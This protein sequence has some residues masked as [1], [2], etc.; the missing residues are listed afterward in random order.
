MR[1]PPARPSRGPQIRIQ[2]C[3]R[4]V[5]S[6][7]V[8][9]TMPKLRMDLNLLARLGRFNGAAPGNSAGFRAG[10]ARTADCRAGMAKA[11]PSSAARLH[12]GAGRLKLSLVSC[13]IAPFP[14]T[15]KREKISFHQIVRIPANGS[16]IR[17]STSTSRATAP[18]GA[19]VRFT[20]DRDQIADIAEGPSRASL[21]SKCRSGRRR[22]R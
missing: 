3:L 11:P 6:G 16:S 14:A 10:K 15:S 18:A 13:P 5:P 12:Q 22:H 8:R 17:R 4:K 21:H 1:P 20:R 9:Q 7:G 2:R 19:R